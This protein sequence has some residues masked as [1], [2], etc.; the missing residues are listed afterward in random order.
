MVD[1]NFYQQLGALVEA[2]KQAREA[3]S[4]LE[5]INTPKQP[6]RPFSLNSQAEIDT[7]LSACETYNAEISEYHRSRRAFNADIEKLEF[8]IKEFIPREL[9][10][11]DIICNGYRV[12]VKTNLDSTSGTLDIDNR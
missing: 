2:W 6:Q 7:Y 9:W 11:F 12:R 4:A 5:T 3:L 10:D 8:T 1:R